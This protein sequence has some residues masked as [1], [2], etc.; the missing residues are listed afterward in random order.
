MEVLDLRTCFALSSVVVRRL[1]EIVVDV[2][3][4]PEPESNTDERMV[5]DIGMMWDKV[6]LPFKC[7]D[8]I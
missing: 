4:P 5:D 1:S 8:A 3:G 6:H 7:D 2:W